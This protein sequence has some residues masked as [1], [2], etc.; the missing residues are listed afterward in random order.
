MK[1][2][3]S[4]SLFLAIL[5]IFFAILIIL[6]FFGNPIS[7]LVAEVAANKYL[8]THYT[9]LDL[10]RDR[11]YYDFKDGSYVVR[12]Q[13]KN[14]IDTNFNLRFNSFGKMKRDTYG[15]RLFNTYRRYMD[16]LDDLGEEI[17][18]DNGLDFELWLRADDD[19]DYR[20]YLTLDQDFDANNLPSKVTADFKAYAEKPSL[21][22]LM[23]GLKKVYEALKVRDIAVSSYSGLVIPND[24]K[25]EDGKAETWK[26]AI[27]VNDVPEEV[28]VDGDMKELKKIYDEG[29][30]ILHK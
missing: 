24:D 19:I 26:N 2:L 12:L 5:L 3:K 7:R 23:N 13:D 10:E 15:E 4:L 9:D 22:D 6:S 8:K 29:N 30:K 27:S 20:E 11:V 25:E 21:D 18:K 14:S 28:I 1:G 16:F 17:A